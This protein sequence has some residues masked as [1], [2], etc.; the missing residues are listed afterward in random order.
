MHR[1]ATIQKHAIWSILLCVW[2]GTM[3]PAQTAQPGAT[4]GNRIELGRLADGD[5]V[6]FVRASAGDWGIE[7]FGAGVVRYTQP[8]PANI[9]VFQSEQNVSQLSSGYQSVRRQA[10]VVVARASVAYE[11]HAAFLVEDRW[12]LSGAV[13]ALTRKVTV[14]H[15]EEKTGFGSAIRL[16]TASTVNWPDADY[17]APGLLYGAPHTRANASGG[18]LFYNAK[19]FSIREDYL[20][21]PLF[22]LSFRD[23][24]WA[25]AMDMSPSG[26]TSREE[27]EAKATTPIIDEQLR[28][29]AL[30][31]RELPAGGVEFG[32][33][34]PGTTNEFSGGFAFGGAV[35]PPAVPLVRRR[36]NPVKAG[37]SQSYQVGFRFGSDSSLL[38]MERDAWRWAWQT[39]KPKAAPLDVE[40]ARRALIDHL[41]DRVL[42]VDG[43][44]G[45]PFIIDSVSGKPGSFRPSLWLA[46]MPSFFRTPPPSPETEAVVQFARSL[47]ID[48][49]PKAAELDLWPKIMMGFCGE[50]IEAA[51]QFLLE[52]DR[53]PGPRG[54]RMRKLGLAI[55]DSFLRLVPSSPV[56]AGEGFDIR[57]G[58]ASAV[59]GEPAFSLRATGED[60]RNMV[61]VCRRERAHGREHPEWLSWVKSYSDW[62]LTQQRKDG[63]FPEEFQGGTG[64][65]KNSSGVTSYA[66]VPLLVRMSQET[67]DK[68][69]LDAAKRAADYI[70]T[71]F[72]SKG[73]YLGA[74]GGEI[75]DKESGML[76]ME[77]F[78]DLY[79]N[80]QEPKWLA[81]AQRAADYTET[82]IWLWNVPMAPGLPDSALGWKHGVSTVGVTGIGTNVPG[83][84]DEYLDWAVP[85][86]ARLYKRTGDAHYLDA[87]RI[88][89]DDTK[90]MLALPGRTYDMLGPGWQQE[91]W[92]MGPGIRGIGAHRTWLPWISVNHLH[93]I[94]A[95][96]EF[97]SAL[98]QQLL[99]GD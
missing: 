45:I 38:S 17:F 1:R 10:G 48:I 71:D 28:F 68:K 77:A 31:A 21:A 11:G 19:L 29:G 62:L 15:T 4:T 12:T 24:R 93:G 95:L 34:L 80:T 51:S 84:V 30:G 59:R 52:A 70:W 14:A 97:D 53:D 44:A 96:E 94:T 5:V 47:G 46:Q 8:K 63:S 72:G 81:R 74:T 56:L 33:W 86:Y 99:K 85:A 75:A 89:L 61:D 83:E 23:G 54:Q 22:G 25:V 36:Y 90:S 26:D 32:F 18:S 66:V 3:L 60:M 78:L 13:L 43:R 9:E 42:V 6:A 50:N 79:D 35:A 73:V 7:I 55:I 58:K 92:R 82:Y 91:H 20:S 67:G 87:A 76:S 49:D 40:A 41:A 27:T 64:K 16:Q 98:Y 39:L 57:T 88:L 2:I 69:Y 37:F 65:V